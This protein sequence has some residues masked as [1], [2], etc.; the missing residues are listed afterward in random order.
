[1]QKLNLIVLSSQYLYHAA[2]LYTYFQIISGEAEVPCVT[3]GEVRHKRRGPEATRRRRKSARD[4]S[5]EV[6]LY[7]ATVDWRED[8]KETQG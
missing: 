4:H 2:E 6:P 8:W 3:F 7:P 1:M 5:H